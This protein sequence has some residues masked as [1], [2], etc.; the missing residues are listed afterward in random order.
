MRRMHFKNN[1]SCIVD[2]DL[3]TMAI[4]YHFPALRCRSFIIGPGE[5]PRIGLLD[6]TYYLHRVIGFYLYRDK[7]NGQPLLQ[8]GRFNGKNNPFIHHENGDRL[9][10]TISNLRL[11]T[12]QEHSIEHA[13]RRKQLT[14]SGR[15]VG[16][17]RKKGSIY[18][19]AKQEIISLY[20]NGY[21]LTQIGV[22]Y[23][24]NFG[25]ILNRLKEW[26]IPRRPQGTRSTQ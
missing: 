17:G 16:A 12:N 15:A 11:T 26:N 24:C 8:P 25:T 21:T 2:Y 1:C 18:D 19:V 14:G 5:Y 20:Q 23:G 3:L 13:A 4:E 22:R 6:K 9:D 10:C 7:M